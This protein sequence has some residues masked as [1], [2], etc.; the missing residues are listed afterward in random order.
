MSDRDVRLFLLD[1]IACIDKVE[2]YVSGV[3]YSDFESDD[4]LIDAVVR[5]LEVIGEAAR[6]VPDEIR[7]KYSEQIYGD[8]V[9]KDCG[10]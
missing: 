4:M 3:S 8:P 5:N 1:I 10:F 2:R 6:Q 7:N 9:A